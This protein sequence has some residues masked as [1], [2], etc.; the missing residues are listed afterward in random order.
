MKLNFKC[1]HLRL[2][3]LKASRAECNEQQPLSVIIITA[4]KSTRLCTDQHVQRN[5]LM[6]LWP[7]YFLSKSV[8]LLDAA[9]SEFYSAGYE[10]M[11]VSHIKCPAYFRSYFFRCD[12]PQNTFHIML[13]VIENWHSP[14]IP[15]LYNMNICLRLAGVRVSRVMRHCVMQFLIS[16]PFEIATQ[17]WK[18]VC[19]PTVTCSLICT[20]SE[21][22]AE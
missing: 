19:F 14:N 4:P 16:I 8:L 20:R 11:H 9:E 17:S 3:R 18:C 7:T 15:P 21:S 6:L 12:L 1:I 10:E 5:S 2:L 13:K 22:S